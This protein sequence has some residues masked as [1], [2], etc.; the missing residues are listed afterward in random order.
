MNERTHRVRAVPRLLATELALRLP[1]VATTGKLFDDNDTLHALLLFEQSLP[2]LTSRERLRCSRCDQTLTD[3]GA[4]R[5]RTDD[6]RLAKPALSQLSYSPE[7]ENRFGLGRPNLNNIVGQGRLEL[8]TSRLSGVRSNHLSYWPG[9]H[10]PRTLFA[11]T[12][13]RE[14]AAAFRLR[15]TNFGYRYQR[16][17]LV[18]ENRVL[19]HIEASCSAQRKAEHVFRSNI[20]GFDRSHSE[21]GPTETIG[22]RLIELLRKEV[23]QPQVPLRLPCY[24]FTPVTNHSL[25]TCLPCGLAQPLLEQSTP[26]V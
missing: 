26:M 4:D 22:S 12:R 5:D 23:I 14:T 15:A 8:P 21:P 11:F 19:F 6:L 25:G 3:S 2:A 24:D 7:F 17:S 10:G 1:P 20:A 9:W 18:P 16:P 13:D